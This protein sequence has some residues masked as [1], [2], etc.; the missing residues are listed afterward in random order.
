M[1][2]DLKADGG[3]VFVWNKS[4][5]ETRNKEM[6]RMYPEFADF[7]NDVNARMYDLEVPFKSGV[8]IHPDF[9]GK[10]SIKKSV[11]CFST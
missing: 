2:K 9:K 8:Y 5:E 4:F 6:A 7:L 11:T 10:S 1:Q 3:T